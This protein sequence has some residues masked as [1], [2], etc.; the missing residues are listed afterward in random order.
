MSFWHA[1]NQELWFIEEKVK[2]VRD[3]L[4]P[5]LSSQTDEITIFN[6]AKI[7]YARLP[8]HC[9]GGGA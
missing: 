5:K 3:Q 7:D 8:A 4:R 2:A 9:E 6:H 1:V